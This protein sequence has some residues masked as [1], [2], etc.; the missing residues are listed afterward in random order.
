MK[1]ANGTLLGRALREMD[2]MVR[3]DQDTQGRS[4]LGIGALIAQFVGYPDGTA[5][6]QILRQYHFA[7]QLNLHNN[8]ETARE[9]EKRVN[10]LMA[11]MDPEWFKGE[12]EGNDFM[13][14]QQGFSVQ[15]ELELE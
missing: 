7:R 1:E 2:N 4:P 5:F 3:L 12:M 9:I 13:L 11:Q 14:V 8:P 10:T 6:G 15:P